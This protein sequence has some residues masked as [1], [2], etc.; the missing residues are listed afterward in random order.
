MPAC[1][2][3]ADAWTTV[4][5]N[6]SRVFLLIVKA[7]R[8]YN[9]VIQ[10]GLAVGSLDASCLIQ[11]NVITLPWVFCAEYLFALCCGCVDNV[12]VAWDVW[13]TIMVKHHLA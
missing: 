9:S 13:L 10:V 12:Y 2:Y 4:N 3:I 6:Y 1:L 11:R 7:Y 8:V 5:I